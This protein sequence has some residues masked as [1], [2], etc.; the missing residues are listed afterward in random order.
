MEKLMIKNVL[1]KFGF[2]RVALVAGAGCPLIFASNAFAQAPPPPPPGEAVAERVIVTGSNIPTAQEQASIPVTTYTAQWLQKSG[3]NTPV[4]GLRQLPTFVGNAETENDSNGGN[5]A[6]NINL[7]GLGPENTL[8]LMNGR[9]LS[10]GGLRTLAPD[11]NLIPLS[12][13]QKVD[14]LKDGASA[15]YGSDAVAGVVNFMMWND[16]RDYGPIYEGAEFELRYGTT[17]D[18][19]ANLRQAWIR[20]GVTGMDGKVA[21]FAA[22]EYY[23]RA[24]LFSRD[25]TISQTGDVS[26]NPIVSLNPPSVAGLGLGGVNNNSPTFA[27]KVFISAAFP[28]LSP[29]GTL[30]LID[31]GNATPTVASYRPFDVPDGTDANRFNFQVF[32][33]AIPPMEKS[34]NYVTGR[35]KVFGDALQVYGDML[36]THERQKNA[37]AGA[38]FNTG[39]DAQQSPFNPFPIDDREF[40]ADGVTPNDNFGNSIVTNVS[41]RLQQELGNRISTFDKDY[42]R[43]VVAVKGDLDFADNNWIS[44]FGYDSG[45]VYERYEEQEIDAG[46]AT[47]TKITEQILAGNFNPFIGQNAPTSGVAPIYNTT[48]PTAPEFL[49]GVP[50]GT[51]AYDNVRAANESSYLGHSF[52]RNKTATWDVTL[53]AHLLPNLWNGG[54]D[55]A[56]GY[57]HRYQQDEQIGDP[58]Q[59]AGDQLG[60]GAV[61][62]AK[63]QQ[64]VN[65]WFGEIKIPFVTSTMNVP[66]VNYF[67]IDYALRYEEF[68][69]HD[70]SNPNPG[71][72]DTQSFPHTLTHFDNGTDHRV[73][74][75]WRPIPDLLLRGTYGTSFRS[76]GPDDLFFPVFQDFPFVFDPVRQSTLQ[77]PEGVWI[78][79]NPNLKP[80]ETTN[81]TAGI[82]YSPKF[83]PG[84]TI[85]TDWY[86]I[87]T[88]NVIVEGDD[89]SQILLSQGVVDPDG[90]GNG[91]GEVNVTGPF[92]GQVGGPGLGITRDQSGNLQAIDSTP[93]NA[94]VRFVQGVDVAANYE[95]PTTNFGKFTFTLGYNHFFT[96]KISPG[97]G[98]PFNDF[99]GNYNNGTLPLAPGAIPFNKGFVRLEWEYKLGP[100][101]LDFVAQGNYIGDY[102]DD[103]G[104]I[105]GNE[106]INPPDEQTAWVLSRRVAEWTSLDL[107][108]SYEFVRPPPVEAPVPGYS[109]EG[110]DFKSPLGKQPAP[111]TAVAESSFWQRMLW[112]TKITA[113]VVN[114]FDRNP[115]TVLGAF[116][117][118]YDTSLYTIRNRFWYVALS[119]KF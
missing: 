81:W 37:L 93:G 116:N 13:I 41:Y 110:K 58:V 85:T 72:P 39:S 62:N 106:Q 17:T 115:P 95:L 76:P 38:P 84:L 18:R 61:P 53:N 27:G 36:Y 65:A 108:A 1:N 5:G 12:P 79:G 30:T 3:S 25:R 66:F 118:N 10:A 15:I 68:T 2:V 11:I 34:M 82:V 112:G 78:R 35:Y 80:E 31:L 87:Y 71:F 91:S 97:P 77:P 86:Q 109:K 103:P 73:T 111:V 55:V 23:N 20:G 7:R 105:A 50:I 8:V 24:G 117:D 63:F 67:E 54:V 40:L 92:N 99:L 29:S 57:V 44:H 28:E 60:F 69:D 46:D 4:E 75:G 9:R 59:A 119:K 51:A 64:V 14:I 56:G 45:I 33:P 100:G 98:L 47:F 83:V 114:A 6:G 74:V 101:I 43:W 102:L 90:Y 52:F 94:G 96:W 49:T 89:F 16:I 48:D 32:T 22:A 42:W 104:F 70:L 21:I 19:D 113:G 88:T 26:N 107:Q